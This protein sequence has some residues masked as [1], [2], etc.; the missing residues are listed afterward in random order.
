MRSA[1]L[2]PGLCLVCLRHRLHLKRTH[3]TL[4]RSLPELVEH[5]HNGLVFQD[6]V[7]LLSSVETLLMDFPHNAELDRMRGNIIRDKKEG[8][9]ISWDDQWRTHVLPLLVD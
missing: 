9:W 1:R 7:S 5:K 6:A 8:R 2:R 4:A 3:L